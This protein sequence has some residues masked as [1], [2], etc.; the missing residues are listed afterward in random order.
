M[1]EDPACMLLA[2]PLRDIGRNVAR[3]FLDESIDLLLPFTQCFGWRAYC[4]LESRN[5]SAAFDQFGATC[6]QPVP[7][8][9]RGYAIILVVLRDYATIG[10]VDDIQVSKF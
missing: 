7:Q 6:F 3:Q 1:H 10:V 8:P 9:P 4:R 2:G 5:G